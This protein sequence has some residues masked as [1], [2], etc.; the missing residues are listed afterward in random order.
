MHSYICGGSAHSKNI[1]EK[2]FGDTYLILKLVNCLPVDIYSI[3]KC[4][5]HTYISKDINWDL[6]YNTV[7]SKSSL[8]M[9]IIY[10]H[11]SQL[12]YFQIH[13]CDKMYL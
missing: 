7:Y 6:Y 13:P 12:L 3:R 5:N 10:S 8:E 2:Q 1:F 4:D 11:Y 9:L